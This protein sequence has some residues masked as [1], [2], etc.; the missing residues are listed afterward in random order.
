MPVYWIYVSVYLNIT[1]VTVYTMK[2]N[3]VLVLNSW[4]VLH[5]R[6]LFVVSE[7]QYI[8]TAGCITVTAGPRRRAGQECVWF[9]LAGVW[10]CLCV[11]HSSAAVIYRYTWTRFQW[12]RLCMSEVLYFWRRFQWWVYSREQLNHMEMCLCTGQLIWMAVKAWMIQSGFIMM[13]EKA[14]FLSDPQKCRGCQW[15]VY[16]LDC[17]WISIYELDSYE[18][19]MA[20]CFCIAWVCVVRAFLTEGVSGFTLSLSHAGGPDSSRHHCLWARVPPHTTGP[21]MFSHR[22]TIS[23]SSSCPCLAAF[24]GLHSLWFILVSF[25]CPLPLTLAHSLTLILSLFSL[26]GFVNDLILMKH[27]LGGETRPHGWSLPFCSLFSTVVHTR[28]AAW[29]LSSSRV[30]WQM[31]ESGPYLTVTIPHIIGLPPM[32]VWH[33][34]VSHKTISIYTFLNISQDIL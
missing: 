20:V 33:L 29:D 22:G 27:R 31:F 1:R 7:S 15:T 32:S 2:S 16:E 25:C 34:R 5:N 6:I 24:S 8:K 14:V 21:C 12:M 28:R 10:C 11:F 30:S 13:N 23:S 3:M 17:L 18:S 9:P 26:L 4:A 19:H